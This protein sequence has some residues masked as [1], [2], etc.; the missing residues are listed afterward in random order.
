V[1]KQ[2]I[3]YLKK[4]LTDIYNLSLESGIFPEQLKIAKVI[5]VH[6][7]G[8]K[9]DINNYR[10][11]ASLFSKVL[12]KLVYN[13][14]IVFIESNGIITD[15]QHGFRAKRSTETALQDFVNN[16]QTAVDNK[17]NPVGLFLDLSKAYDVL[18]HKL[19]LDKLNVRGIRGTANLWME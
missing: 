6:K 2:C 19:L 12:E 13:R 9:R 5:P 14:I 10:P 8:N 11:I 17:M 18:E 1:V 15:V 4:P 7:K 3:D 16:V